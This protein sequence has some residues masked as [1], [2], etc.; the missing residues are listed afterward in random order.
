MLSFFNLFHRLEEKACLSMK[1]FLIPFFIVVSIFGANAQVQVNWACKVIKSNDTEEGGYGP[2][3]A[4][5]G[6]ANILSGGTD[7][8]AWYIGFYPGLDE[9]GK[10]IF[11]ESSGIIE[12]TYELCQPVL[13]AQIIITE[14]INSGA[15]TM[16]VVYDLQNNPIQVYKGDAKLVSETFRMWSIPVKNISKPIKRIKISA[17]PSK[18]KDWNLIS[19]VG[20]TSS[21]TPYV[22][23]ASVI[24]P[25]P[26]LNTRQSFSSVLDEFPDIR[27]A[28]FTSDKKTMFITVHLNSENSDIYTSNFNGKEWS[29]P[30]SIGKPINN[31]KWNFPAAIMPCNNTIYI[32]NRYNADGSYF[33]GAVSVS[34]KIKD[35]WS[36]PENLMFEDW[37]NSHKFESYTVSYD[38]KY[39]VGQIAHDVCYGE[40]DLYAFLKKPDGTYG[41]AI[42]LGA[43][44]NTPEDECNPYLASDSKTLFFCS[45]GHPGYGELDVFMTRR[46]DDTWQNWTTPVNL[47]PKI[48]SPNS[49]LSFSITSDGTFAYGYFN[50]TKKDKIDIYKI[51]IS[52]NSLIRPLPTHFFC[53]TVHDGKTGKEM[54]ARVRI[55]NLNNGK[56][57]ADFTSNKYNGAFQMMM[58]DKPGNYAIYAEA[59]GYI[60]VRRQYNTLKNKKYTEY[61]IDLLLFP[62]ELNAKV[63]LNTVLFKQG[64][65]ELLSQSESE[66]MSVLDMMNGNPTMTIEIRGHTDNVGN[67]RDLYKLST[68]RAL[69][70]KTFLTQHGVDPSRISTK[71][72]G[73][74]VPV[75]GNKTEEERLQNRRVEFLITKF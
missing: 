3:A 23:A 9:K 33:D 39:I 4:L 67:P 30:V 63:A 7:F 75:N 28:A 46:L 10:V 29:K 31:E 45:S 52:E 18:V 38:T 47:G 20:V 44:V 72:F 26:F 17:E 64:T 24:S 42:N 43:V 68:D 8:A 69:S 13:P 25:D 14:P 22:P 2:S 53:G 16:V 50:N 11:Y 57:E 70:V 34:Y 55:Q 65:P 40:G 27:S 6:P 66:L 15:V 71:G 73:G 56:I 12:T 60:S 61:A 37:K 19:A 49:E 35:G 59:P 74:T 21:T 48:N 5:G 54:V 58:D 1:S 62:L 51:D 41:K 36:M 32:V